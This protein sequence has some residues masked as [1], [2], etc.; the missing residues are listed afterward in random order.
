MLYVGK[1]SIAIGNNILATSTVNNKAE[2][3]ATIGIIMHRYCG[4]N[5]KIISE[6]ESKKS[7]DKNAP[8][9]TEAF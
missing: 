2:Y 3:V 5:Y 8:A 6:L 1:V 4:N 7:I 9:E